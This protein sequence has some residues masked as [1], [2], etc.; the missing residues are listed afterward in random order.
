MQRVLDHP[1]SDGQACAGHG[2]PC[3]TVATIILVF[4]GFARCLTNIPLTTRR[5]VHRRQDGG[6]SL[7]NLA[8]LLWMCEHVELVLV[9]RG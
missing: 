5:L 4:A 1:L 7:L 6:K 9:D 3:P 8:T 2:R